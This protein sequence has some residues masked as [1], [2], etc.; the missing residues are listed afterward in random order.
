MRRPLVRFFSLGHQETVGIGQSDGV[1]CQR[2]L[3]RLFSGLGQV[4]S[5]L[6]LPQT[7]VQ[8]LTARL[9]LRR[10]GPNLCPS[11]ATGTQQG[12]KHVHLRHA[13]T[14]P[15]R[16]AGKAARCQ[17]ALLRHCGGP[18]DLWT[19]QCLQSSQKQG[20]FSARR[21]SSSSRRGAKTARVPAIDH[22]FLGCGAALLGNLATRERL[23]T[24]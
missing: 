1:N 2:S 3:G 11:T 5:E 24:S 4:S 12:G 9:S 6:K 17:C 18:V 21:S 16:C 22:D 14:A 20:L 8:V 23:P 13:G 19:K 10:A 15:A 7:C